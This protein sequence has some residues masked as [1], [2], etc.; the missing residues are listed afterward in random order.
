MELGVRCRLHQFF[1]SLP[2]MHTLYWG[3]AWPY[4]GRLLVM[5]EDQ[6]TLI[7]QDVVKSYSSQLLLSG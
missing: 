3:P 1:V 4:R 7:E 2:Q 6:H 5:R